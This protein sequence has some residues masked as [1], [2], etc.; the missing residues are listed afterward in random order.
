LKGDEWVMGFTLVRI[1]AAEVEA[2][3]ELRASRPTATPPDDVKELVQ[4]KA[5]EL[6]LEHA[7]KVLDLLNEPGN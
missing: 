6:E 2:D 1:A 5:A 3:H 7:R 4:T